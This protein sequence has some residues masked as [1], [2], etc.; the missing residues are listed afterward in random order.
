[1]IA[2]GGLAAPACERPEHGTDAAS[3]AP[4]SF[5]EARQ[6]LTCV[7]VENTG[8][9]KTRVD[10][11]VVITDPSD[12][13]KDKVNYGAVQQMLT[14]YSTGDYRR[15]LM[16]FNLAGAGVPAGSRVESAELS[17]R[18]AQSLKGQNFDVLAGTFVWNEATVTWHEMSLAPGGG[19]GALLASVPTASVAANSTLYITLPGSVVEG[20]IDPATNTG[21][22]FDHPSPGRTTIASSE[23]PSIAPRPKLAVCYEPPSC[24]DGVMN[25]T[26]TGIDCGGPCETCA[27]VHDVC[28]TGVAL[29]PAC[30]DPCAGDVCV[31]RPECCASGWDEA[32][33]DL[34]GALCSRGACP[35]CG[36]HTVDPGET[37][38]DGNAVAGD[39][40]D[41]GCQLEPPPQCRDGI[42]E[43]DG[44]GLIDCGD[45]DCQSGCPGFCAPGQTEIQV[46]ASGLPYPIV[47]GALFHAA[48]SVPVD[49][50][51]TR[52][53]VKVD[54]Q[55]TWDSDLTFTVK[56]PSGATVTLAANR[57]GDGDDYVS[58]LFD[59]SCATPIGSAAPPFT[60]CF[61]PEQ[62]LGVLSGAGSLGTW[63]VGVQ[64]DGIGDTGSL[65]AVQLSLC[66][67]PAAGQC[68]NG[69][70]E[71]S[72]GCDDGNTA[73]GD[74]CDAACQVEP[75]SAEA[76]C[77][78]GLDEDVDGLVDC[79]DPDCASVGLC[80]FACAPGELRL[81]AAAADLP[82]PI[83][84]FATA[85]S[86]VHVAEAGTL[87]RAGVAVDLAH[88]WDGDLALSLR[89]PGGTLVDLSLNNGASG[90]GYQ[91]TIFD[92]SCP[93]PVTS[94]SGPFPGCYA[95]EGSLAALAG[96]VMNGDWQLRVTDVS[97]GDAGTLQSVKILLCYH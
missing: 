44:D 69:H 59:S 6:N 88:T 14:G 51:V 82:K 34:V 40:C 45:P 38:D 43:A 1:L 93:A 73:G 31:A 89:S 87:V 19:L 41:S 11:A 91:G 61:A 39:G 46:A 78:D 8:A 33:K 90:Q 68:G 42:D 36:D 54:A 55:H 94:G 75:P 12:P 47:D 53:A 72:E 92:S 79:A 2:A 7:S 52:V 62:S 64:D 70:L 18:M 49:G 32:C 60:G 81:V 26:E 4:P 86:V 50:A 28:S 37:C 5:A 97:L 22:V 17:V 95:P 77:D 66:V 35:R 80:V 25:Q 21:L 58:T 57:G 83:V 71:G 3:T 76:S 27:C 24:T 84:D 56:A 13:N 63:R 10:D 15:I 74:G 23:A 96:Q 20:W 29:D 65:A 30:A 48:L 85:T 16:R 67:V 9:V